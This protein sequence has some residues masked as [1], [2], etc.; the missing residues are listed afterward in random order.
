MCSK[1]LTSVSLIIQRMPEYSD[2]VLEAAPLALWNRPY[3]YALVGGRISAER[4]HEVERYQRLR[5]LHCSIV[6]EETVGLTFAVRCLN[7][8]DAAW[9]PA[10]LFVG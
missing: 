7:E 9:L 4:Q 10:L 5:M 6:I 8:R 2:R 3:D 1:R